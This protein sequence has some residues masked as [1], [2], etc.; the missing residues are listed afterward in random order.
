MPTTGFSWVKKE[1]LKRTKLN[2]FKD[3]TLTQV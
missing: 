2:V 3:Y 1:I